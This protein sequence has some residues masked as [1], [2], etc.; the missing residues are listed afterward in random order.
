VTSRNT[1]FPQHV[2]VFYQ[3]AAFRIK[4][5]QAHYI[6]ADPK[7]PV[8]FDIVPL[9]EIKRQFD[10]CTGLCVSFP[11]FLLDTSPP[12]PDLAKLR[13]SAKS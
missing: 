1:G 13:Y 8:A 7:A 11:S 10:V 2:I 3:G 6:P 5:M 9:H 4:V 12:F